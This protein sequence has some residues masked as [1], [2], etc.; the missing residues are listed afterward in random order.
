MIQPK[1]LIAA[2]AGILLFTKANAQDSTHYDLGRIQLKKD[3]SQNITVKGADLE[4]MPFTNLADAINVWFYGTY[5]NS[6][7]LVYIIDGNLVNDVNAYSIYDID[8]VTLVQNAVS[9]MSGSSGPEQLVLIKTKRSKTKGLSITANAQAN[10]TSLY[11]NNTPGA[12]AN[13]YQKGLKST[14]T[15]YQQY[16]VSA[17]KNTGNINYGVSADYIRDV[18]PVITQSGVVYIVPQTL[19]R[20]KFNTYLDAKIG[21]SLLK[22]TA[23]YD[24]QKEKDILD[25]TTT[26]NIFYNYSNSHIFDGTLSLT[27]HIAPGFTN[28]I[29]GDYNYY[30]EHDYGND[31]ETVQD[32]Y[33]ELNYK[34][35]IY[36][37]NIVAY[38]NIS[39]TKKL[40]DWTF[41]P[42][43][44]LNFR[45]FRDSS[46]S[47]E[48][49]VDQSGLIEGSGY[50]YGAEMA[51]LFLL[52]PSL[53]FYYKTYFNVQAGFLDD[54]STIG[55]YNYANSKPQN[56]LPF[57]T[58]SADVL[59]LINANSTVALK[60][61]GSFSTND[62]FT[63]NSNSLIDFSDP[64]VQVPNITYRFPATETYSGRD[65]Y[66]A[67]PSYIYQGISK[68]FKTFSAGLSV[69]AQNIPVSINYFFEKTSYLS[70][71][72]ISEPNGANGEQ[73]ASVYTN[74]Y[75][76]LNRVSLNYKL[77]TNT[78]NWQ[79]NVNATMIKQTFPD[80]GF[81]GTK[82]TL[83]GGEWTG[84]WV[85]RLSYNNLFVGADLLYQL[86]QK[87]YS[88]SN[89][90]ATVVTKINSFS[91]QN[92]Y[93]GYR[94]KIKG[95]KDPEIFANARNIF[96]NRKEDI[97]N[98][99]KY[100]G[101]G[102]NFGL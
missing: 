33:Q 55:V 43:I 54:L 30:L 44:N 15:A 92:L 81:T 64:G 102:L 45:T 41:E 69:S 31:I 93:A 56:V 63:D 20:I 42:N 61:F 8:E 53:S 95:L 85:N 1:L 58:A 36:N 38:D 25:E 29:H 9:T 16:Y 40:G 70:P 86:G 75:L 76:L 24:P 14:T 60:V 27:T 101:V 78:V 82:V 18:Q 94:L 98:G 6:A 34:Q 88:L 4:K 87:E 67:S 57:I 96:Q 91:L 23:A 74:T 48:V 35:N 79:T 32:G 83:G 77:S 68:T 52:T 22:V 3:F 99:R 84:G 72:F 10:I 71:V 11:T 97:T 13:T 89:T 66:T 49:L 51:H 47:S 65:I 80:E 90:G 39:Y 17:R 62:I 50:G 2:L 21:S 37:H 100:Y 59:H 12:S 26:Q 19:N 73:I 46:Y 28:V 7:T 5:S